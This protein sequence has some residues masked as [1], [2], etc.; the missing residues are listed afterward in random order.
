MSMEIKKIV[1]C[2]G[3]GLGSSLMIRL[4]AEK[5]LKEMRRSDIEVRH[6]SL[7]ATSPDEA[8]LFIVG[9][10]LKDFAD[11]FPHVI[12]LENILS[13]DELKDKLTNTLNENA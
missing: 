5:V 11:S 9:K 1:C 10:E 2:C 7:A 6:A 12:L 13:I 8:D 4:N 3:S